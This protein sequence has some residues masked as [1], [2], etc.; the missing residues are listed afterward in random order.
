MSQVINSCLVGLNSVGRAFWGYAAG[1]FVQAGVL[2][3]LLLIIDFLLR[4]RVRAAL[5]A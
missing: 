3:V 4:R 5:R 2:I 1:M